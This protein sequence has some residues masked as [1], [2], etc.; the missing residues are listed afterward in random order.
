VI[1]K[2]DPLIHPITRLSIC[3]LLAAGADWVEFAAL[4]D[5]AGISDSVLSKQSRVLEEAGY[6]EVRKGSVGRRPRTWFRLTAEGRQA[7]QG[8]LAWL[9]QLEEAVAASAQ[10]V[11]QASPDPDDLPA[12][13]HRALP[14]RAEFRAGLLGVDEE[15]ERV[16]LLVPLHQTVQGGLAEFGQPAA[17][18][19]AEQARLDDL[20][21]EGVIALGDER[22]GGV[23][24]PLLAAA[25]QQVE[26]GG[27]LGC[28]GRLHPGPVRLPVTGALVVEPR[29]EVVASHQV[30]DD[31]R[32]VLAEDVR[33]AGRGED[34]RQ[35]Q[36]PADP[37]EHLAVQ[38]GQG[39]HEAGDGR[40]GEQVGQR[41]V[42]VDEQA[43]L[44]AVD[45]RERLKQPLG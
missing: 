11:R 32:R 29:G 3:G 20:Q 41:R 31:R 10:Q 43:G 15:L 45:E 13:P 5:A 23:G 35:R 27:V 19:V 28:G 12:S 1:A 30:G 14:D 16:G 26:R 44:Q 40:G 33:E 22:G 4:R 38:L 36:A 37:V 9:S 39:R 42:A 18:G 7:F 2:P 25:C 8:H 6:V 17:G 24:E 34:V 21:C